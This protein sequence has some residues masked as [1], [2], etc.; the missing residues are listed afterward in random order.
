MSD[1]KSRDEA[2]LLQQGKAFLREGNTLAAL[3]RFEKCYSISPTPEHQSYLGFC[4]SVERGQI[5][6]ALELCKEAISKET[7]N[8]LHYLN[9]AKVCLKA[10]MKDEAIATLRKGLS[11][12]DSE[13]I[14]ALLQG[15]GIRRNPL[16]TFLPRSN[17]LNKYLGLLLVRLRLR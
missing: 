17:F 14:K 16:F 11:H 4:I 3:S 2:E 8:P 10:D 12:G 15:L 9:Y 5:T 1:D 7:G 13:E 6:R